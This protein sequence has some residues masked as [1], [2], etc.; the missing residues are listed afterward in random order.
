[1]SHPDPLPQIR[2]AAEALT[3]PRTNREPRWTWVNRNRK[4]LPDHVT[5]L[6]GLIQQLRELTEP[7]A[8]TDTAGARAIPDSRPPV[9]LD[10]VSLLA[11]IEFG[12]ARRCLEFGLD[13][14]DT[15]ESSLRAI[16]GRA[17]TCN[18]ATQ[19]VL[20]AELRSWRNQAE[21]I[22]RWR[23]GAVEL[24]APCPARIGDGAFATCGARG[25]LLAN[26]DTHAAW[27]TACGTSWEPDDAEDLFR[28][29]KAYAEQ[30]RAAA[31]RVRAK[32]RAAK[33][34]D[35][36]AQEAALE[37]MRQEAAAAG[38]SNGRSAA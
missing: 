29:V 6:P 4:A 9:A 3:D 10:A 37:R 36:L 38:P 14:R 19:F 32:V 27:C 7:G 11:S 30:S 31:E 2:E 16:V 22:C 34:A 26:P 20:A 17:S 18:S 28:H 13:R 35:R 23:T 15:V 8:T 25:S 21:V 24:V 5:T 33:E 12:V 1:M